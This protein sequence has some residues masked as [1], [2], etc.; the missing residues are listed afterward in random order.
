MSLQANRSGSRERSTIGGGRDGSAVSPLKRVLFASA[1]DP[2]Q[3]FGSFEEQ[4]FALCREFHARGGLF[5]PIYSSPLGSR[6]DAEYR[7]AGVAAEWLD[8][9]T[10]QLRVLF[11]LA[12]IVRENAIEVVHWNFYEPIRNGYVW[13]LSLLV[14][15]VRH[16]FT[17][18]ISRPANVATSCGWAKRRIKRAVNRRYEKIF[19][20]SEFVADRLKDGTYWRNVYRWTLL[21][22]TDRFVPSSEVRHDVRRRHEVGDEFVVLVVGQL[23]PEKGIDVALKAFA[24][25]GGSARLWIVGDGV[26][27]G[28]LEALARELG[29]DDRVRFLG[30]QWNVAPFMQA[31][32]CL[33]C[34]SLWA[35]AAGL[36]NLEAQACGLPV[37][38]SRIGGIPEHVDDERTG[39][40]V[41]PG[42][43]GALSL[44]L[45][46]LQSDPQALHALRADA[47]AW[48]VGRF[49][50]QK[51]I[52]ESIGSYLAS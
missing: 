40:L 41:P 44:A 25:L 15:G 51:R 18:H 30:I 32:D 39:I 33:V 29:L 13:G 50:I 36:V 20:V 43:F 11:R 46:R 34:P 47:R 42:D 5:L 24:A 27:R 7:A 17:D 6:T 16:Y 35:E 23:I 48:A 38:A 14:P 49:S 52:Q 21:V 26:E 8:L 3:K 4:T 10:F 1:I 22:N 12:R 9:R 2:S 31:A 28:A 45:R 37:I 19:C